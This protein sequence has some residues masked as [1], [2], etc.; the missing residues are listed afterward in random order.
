MDEKPFVKSKTQRLF[1]LGKTVLKAGGKYAL[2]QGKIKTEKIIH[3]A[4][5]KLI[6]KKETL[7]QIKAATELIS[8]LGNMKG[9]A[10]KLGQMLSITDDLLLSKEVTDL[11]KVLQ[12][13]TSYMP[14]AQVDE[15]FLSNFSKIPSELFKNFEYKAIAAASIG[16]VHKAQLHSG[17]FVAIKIQYPDI[18]DVIRNDLKNIDHLKNLVGIIIPDHPKIDPIIEELKRSLIEECNYIR[19]REN[20]IEFKSMLKDDF[21]KILIPSTYEDYCTKKVLTMDYMT[22]ATFDETLDWSKK[23]REEI[24]KLYYHYYLYT[25]FH[26]RLFHSDPQHGNFLFNKD[27]MILLDFGSTMKLEKEFIDKYIST[28]KSVF[29]KDYEVFKFHMIDFGIFKKE[30]AEEQL[31]KFYQLLHE[32][33]APYSEEGSFPVQDVNPFK[34][35]LDF[36]ISV[37]F[38]HRGV[39]HK[40]FV[41]LD[42]ANIG[43]YMK[44]KKWGADIDWVSPRK[45]YLYK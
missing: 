40:N 36:A 12:K 7:A 17:E 43:M 27:E 38:K 5:N 10:M 32:Y 45:K 28:I 26:K 16:Q 3:D 19:E 6:E 4:N 23:D 37:P 35:F 15:V 13:E 1:S 31:I 22:G 42:R 33:I 39:P 44:L 20:I 24:S 18:E 14:K 21:P 9:A 41:L 34:S 25:V 2:A 29:E 11:F 30:V 8:A